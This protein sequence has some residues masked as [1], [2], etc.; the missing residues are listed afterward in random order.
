MLLIAIVKSMVSFFFLQVQTPGGRWLTDSVAVFNPE[1]IAS[2]P[3]GMWIHTILFTSF[4]MLVVL[5][6][7]DFRRLVLLVQGFVRAS[8]VAV[9]YREESAL[10]SRVSIF[11]LFN[12][13]LMASLFAWQASGVIFVDYPEPV[14]VFWI[15]LAILV[16]YIV[17]IISIRFLGFLFEMREAAQEYVYNIVLFNKTVGLVLFPVTLC[18]AY[19][20]QLPQDWLVGIG[21]VCWGIV[22]L[23]RFVRLS[24]IGLSVR[25]V[26]VLYII[27]YLCTLEIL[28][29][30]V[31]VKALVKLN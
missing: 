3:G 12:F 9:L 31:I 20:R 6:V 15:A 24:W 5:R 1:V 16:T 13:I 29:F 2:R 18:L 25:G 4:T 8:S 21:L 26:S 27:L 10:S 11:L 19:A 30:V 14:A 17:K 7:F 22:L 23:Y 28:P